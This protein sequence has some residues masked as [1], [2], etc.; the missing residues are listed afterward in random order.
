[1]SRKCRVVQPSEE[2]RVSPLPAGGYELATSD[3]RLRFLVQLVSG[4]VRVVRIEHTGGLEDIVYLMR[5]EEFWQF[6]EMQ[7]ADDAR[8]QYPIIHMQ[9]RDTVRALL[10]VDQQDDRPSYR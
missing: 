1:M 7:N 9:L 8:F 5:F 6:E 10:E 2:L 3:A 4:V